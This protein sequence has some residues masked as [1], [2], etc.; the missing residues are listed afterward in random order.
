MMTSNLDDR[1]FIEQQDLGHDDDRNS[2]S[3]ND[4]P[5]T[6]SVTSAKERAATRE[7]EEGVLMHRFGWFSIRPNF[8]Q[9][10]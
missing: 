7:R 5:D 9:A 4:D 6:N 10:S 8:L 1:T 2:N 3:Y